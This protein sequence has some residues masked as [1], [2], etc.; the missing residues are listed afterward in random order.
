MKGWIINN[1]T[2]FIIISLKTSIFHKLFIYLFFLFFVNIFHT[3]VRIFMVCISSVFALSLLIS[4]ILFFSGTVWQL[5]ISG[6]FREFCMFCMSLAAFFVMFNDSEF[7][8]SLSLF[9]TK[10]L[11]LGCSFTKIADIVFVSLPVVVAW[12]H[13]SYE[14][15]K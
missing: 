1:A 9:P 5:Q 6:R 15:A 11:K 7:F 2:I 4:F 12:T 3:A 8:F 14:I 13:F 10:L